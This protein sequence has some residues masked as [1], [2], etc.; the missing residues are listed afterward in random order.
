MGTPRSGP[1]CR[2]LVVVGAPKDAFQIASTLAREVPTWELHHAPD[3]HEA[4]RMLGA[5]SYAAVLIEQGAVETEA[6]MTRLSAETRG[7]PVVILSTSKEPR[8]V[9]QRGATTVAVWPK[10]DLLKPSARPRFRFFPGSRSIR[11]GTRHV[12][13]TRRE[14]DMLACLWSRAGCWVADEELLSRIADTRYT[15]DTSLVR[16][17]LRRLREKIGTTSSTVLES[18][19]GKGHRLVVRTDLSQRLQQL[20]ADFA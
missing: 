8:R 13:L 17:Y 7:A 16:V 2:I 18:E 14:A 11:V 19:P 4:L 6:A 20:V 10:T 9:Q 15:T 3:A 5:S 1:D 12:Q